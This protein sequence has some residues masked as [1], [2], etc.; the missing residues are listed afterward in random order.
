VHFLK[1][2]IPTTATVKNLC[3]FSCLARE[4]EREREREIRAKRDMY[5]YIGGKPYY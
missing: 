5:V 4:R 1:I 3:F 2:Y